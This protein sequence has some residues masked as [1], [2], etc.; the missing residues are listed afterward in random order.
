MLPDGSINPGEMTGFNHYALGAIA[1]WLYRHV[2]GLNA[3]APGFRVARI[4][5]RPGGGLDS[6]GARHETPY[7]PLEV[8]W[9]IKDGAATIDFTVPVGVTAI[10]D[11]PGAPQT[12]FAH[13][14]H[15]VELTG[16]EA[17]AFARA[18]EGSAH[19]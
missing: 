3:E 5:P 2:A 16:E 14:S 4:A 10:L 1:D 11:L 15:S 19:A 9:S 8:R 6:A 18:G 13:G 17:L 7:G 12:R